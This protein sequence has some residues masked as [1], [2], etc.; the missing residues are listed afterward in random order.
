MVSTVE[1]A[2]EFSSGRDRIQPDGK[3]NMNKQG[4]PAPST[5]LSCTTG[6]EESQGERCHDS[7]GLTF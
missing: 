3:Q 7:K 5:V 4:M 6:E 1:K 2:P